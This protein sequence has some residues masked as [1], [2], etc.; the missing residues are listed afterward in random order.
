MQ[1]PHL[2]QTLGGQPEGD[3]YRYYFEYCQI[4]LASLL[5]ERYG[6]KK[7]FPEEDLQ[8]LLLGV[9]S[10]L[11]FLQEKG[12]SHG[13]NTFPPLSV[14]ICTQEI[15]FDSNSSSFK[16]LD[17]HL[18]NG[19]AFAMQQLLQGK[20]KH[21]SPECYSNPN[22]LSEMTLHKN[23][24]WCLGMVILEASVLKTSDQLYMM[25]LQPYAIQERINEV[26]QIYNPA[27]ADNIAMMLNWNQEERPDP[28][29]LFNYLLEQ[30]RIA[31]EPP[32]NLQPPPRSQYQPYQQGVPPQPTQ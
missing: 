8:A 11:S 31:Q 30:Q 6:T 27:L 10:A 7:Y 12:I 29:N 17:S 16:I 3:Q 21:L 9:S 24:V 18:I 20:F 5:Q 22:N 2:L 14:D 25:G 4:T 26:A 1:H 28:V 13:G 32:V 15:Y 23:D 19:R